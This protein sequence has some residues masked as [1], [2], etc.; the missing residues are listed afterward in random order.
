V[1]EQIIT[2]TEEAGE[3]TLWLIIPDVPPEYADGLITICDSSGGDILV[4][5]DEIPALIEALKKLVEQAP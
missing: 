3:A 5:R 4:H 2:V 1:S